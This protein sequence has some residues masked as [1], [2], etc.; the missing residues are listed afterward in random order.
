ME[1]AIQKIIE[2]K[3]NPFLELHNGSCELVD[4]EGGVATVK[5]TGGCVGCPSSQ[6]TLYNGVR[7]IL[8]REI[9][10]IEDVVLGG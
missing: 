1:E 6:I 3:V 5:L 10:E 4:F 8:I 7:P 9:P 2:E